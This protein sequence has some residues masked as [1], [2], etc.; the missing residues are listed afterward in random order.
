MN[1][2]DACEYCKG[3]ETTLTKCTCGQEDMF[4]EDDD[5]YDPMTP[6]QFEAYIQESI[7]NFRINMQN[8]KAEER[9]FPEWMEMFVR[10]SEVGTDEEEEYW[11]RRR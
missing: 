5:N 9:S 3:Y 7:V 1:W 10:W 4:D 11:G 6:F 8:E 2:H